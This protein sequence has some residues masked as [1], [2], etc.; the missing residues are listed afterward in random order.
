M[1]KLVHAKDGGTVN[2]RT[3]ICGRCKVRPNSKDLE[4]VRAKDQ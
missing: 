3:L 2:R 1:K 4:L